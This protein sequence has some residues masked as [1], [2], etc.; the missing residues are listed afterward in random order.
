MCCATVS[1]RRRCACKSLPCRS[2][3]LYR[4]DS[5]ADTR[6]GAGGE[7]RGIIPLTTRDRG[8][9]RPPPI[10]DSLDGVDISLHH[11]SP[12][13]LHFLSKISFLRILLR[14][15][16]FPIEEGFSASSVV[17]L[18]LLSAPGRGNGF[19]PHSI[20]FSSIQF[21]SIQFLTS[22]CATDFHRDEAS[23]SSGR[24]PRRRILSRHQQRIE[25]IDRHLCLRTRSSSSSRSG[26]RPS[27]RLQLLRR[28]NPSE[29]PGNA[30]RLCLRQQ[31]PRAHAAVVAC[32]AAVQFDDPQPILR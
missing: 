5:R 11:F 31:R 20:Q 10:D 30:P 17:G 19:K 23:A 12:S 22:A 18:K 24:R 16:F 26:G 9:A 29:H 6:G 7:D 32:R 13:F 21:N 28:C 14:I 3:S 4:S 15:S 2:R 27:T 1:A 8:E 25:W